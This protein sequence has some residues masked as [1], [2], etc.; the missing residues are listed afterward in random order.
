MDKVMKILLW[1]PLMCGLMVSAECATTKEGDIHWEETLE[2]W[3]VAAGAYSEQLQE[4]QAYDQML[5]Q[6]QHQQILM[7]PAQPLWFGN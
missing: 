4:Q 2:I 5:L 7:Q 6:Q 3:A 1:M